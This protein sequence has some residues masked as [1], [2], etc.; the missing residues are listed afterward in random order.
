[1]P[2]NPPFDAADPQAPFPDDWFVP[3][4]APNIDP[5]PDDWYV[6][7]G[8]SS[9]SS[10]PTAPNSQSAPAVTANRNTFPSPSNNSRAWNPEPF[11]AY[12]SLIPASRAGA[13]AWQPPFFLPPDPFAPQNIP[14][15]AWV[16]PPP[17]FPPSLRRFP[18]TASEPP[19]VPPTGGA[20]GLLGGI[21]RLPAV[22]A[23]PNVPPINDGW[24]LLG[25]IARLPA[26]S[27]PPNGPTID[28]GWGLLDGIARLP[29]V[30]APPSG[31]PIDDGWGL[32]G[33]IA[34]LPASASMWS[35]DAAPG[36]FSSMSRTQPVS[37][38][39]SAPFS[40]APFEAPSG[41]NA[42]AL[43]LSLLR[44]L[45]DSGR[46]STPIQLAGTDASPNF[47]TGGSF[48][49]SSN[50]FQDPGTTPATY[51][52]EGTSSNSSLPARSGSNTF[53]KFLNALNPI[54]SANAAEDEGGGLPPALAQALVQGLLDAATAKQLA[55]QQRILQ[56]AQD[57]RRELI[58]VAQG[59]P[60]SPALAAALEAS[61][62]PRPTGYAA[63]HIAA[64]NAEPAKVARE[65]LQ[66]FN[67][68]INDV[69]NGVF[70]P[71]NR[72]T[73]VIAGENIHSTLHTKE[74]YDAV[75]EALMIAKNREQ[76]I[77]IL[78]GIGQALQS[79]DF[80]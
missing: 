67:I 16:T 24:G 58:E 44:R 56:E 71:A 11:A 49:G 38:F 76:A 61:G 65:I 23:P 80:P 12:W 26:A 34:R 72:A 48:D 60:S 39:G 6:P 57:A 70:L 41:I 1:M 45:A 7:T 19:D 55:E 25:G 28:D 69:S 13:M 2:P 21:A 3:T 37:N 17:T 30:S 40:G 43:Q 63:H 53:S 15:S 59:R 18:S 46:P 68:G 50:A 66:K 10:T 8:S 47:D 52:D 33:G 64:G 74:Y 78:R 22:S 32:P 77:D 79:G 42:Q 73:Q 14:A 4:N 75:N 54:S 27:A 62:V 29:A 36:L 35:I 51:V 5:Y 20:Y 9:A 31:P